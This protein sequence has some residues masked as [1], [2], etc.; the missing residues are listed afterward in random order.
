MRALYS[1]PLALVIGLVSLLLALRSMDSVKEFHLFKHHVPHLQGLE[2][3][4]R[5]SS[6]RAEL[7]LTLV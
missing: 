4:T 3:V 6:N 5:L 1:L 2:K 7:M